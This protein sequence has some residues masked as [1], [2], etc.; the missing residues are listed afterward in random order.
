[1]RHNAYLGG[2]FIFEYTSSH[3][4]AGPL[5]GFRPFSQ[6]RTVTSW[7]QNSSANCA[8]VIPKRF[9]I[10]RIRAGLKCFTVI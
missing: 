5:G 7:T 3:F 2:D 8:C 6:C 9:R 4:L 10:L 1:M